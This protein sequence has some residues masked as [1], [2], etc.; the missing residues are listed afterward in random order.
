[1]QTATNKPIYRSRWYMPAFSVLLGLLMLG[2]FWIGGDVADGL[3]A[4]GASPTSS[5]SPAP[6]AL[7]V[8]PDDGA[9]FSR[10]AVNRSL[11]GW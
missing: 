4:L 8:L 6:L 11:G 1:M 2:A 5:R 9:S 7:V 10:T 3:W